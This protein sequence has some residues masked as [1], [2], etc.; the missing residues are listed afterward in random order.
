LIHLKDENEGRCSASW[1]R[2]G[3]TEEERCS[4]STRAIVIDL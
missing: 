4:R 3:R 1:Q 2:L